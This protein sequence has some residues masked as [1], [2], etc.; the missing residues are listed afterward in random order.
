MSMLFVNFSVID[1]ING[2]VYTKLYKLESSK[3]NF[4]YAKEILFCL[5]FPECLFRFI[6]KINYNGLAAT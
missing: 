4:F 1:I 2:D 3:G 6:K 5:D